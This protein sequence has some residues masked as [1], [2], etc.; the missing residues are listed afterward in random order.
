VSEN[1]LN[2]FVLIKFFG[3]ILIC[4]GIYLLSNDEKGFLHDFLFNTYFLIMGVG[5]LF[6]RKWAVIMFIPPAV[7]FLIISIFFPIPIMLLPISVIFILSVLMI[8]SWS[9]LKWHDKYWI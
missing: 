9:N 8:L 7:I 2:R 5:F 6:L 1:K 3:V 4:F